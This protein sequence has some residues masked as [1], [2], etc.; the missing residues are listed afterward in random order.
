MFALNL[1]DEDVHLVKDD[2]LF[3]GQTDEDLVVMKPVDCESY[4]EQLKREKEFLFVPSM[5]AGMK[6]V[7]IY[8]V[9]WFLAPFDLLNESCNDYLWQKREIFNCSSLTLIMQ[10]SLERSDRMD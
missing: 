5:L 7:L 1:Q 2:D 6:I 10:S 3:L 9:S 4:T 8:L